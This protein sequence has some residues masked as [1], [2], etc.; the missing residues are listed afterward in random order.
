M[1]YFCGSSGLQALLFARRGGIVV[2]GDS[3][4]PSHFVSGVGVSSIYNKEIRNI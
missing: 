3:P 2:G 1:F 4:L